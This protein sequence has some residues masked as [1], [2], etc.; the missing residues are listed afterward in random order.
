M[1]YRQTFLRPFMADGIITQGKSDVF[2]EVLNYLSDA[3]QK[4]WRKATMR[5]DYTDEQKTIYKAL[6][7]KFDKEY[8]KVSKE[9][10]QQAQ[11]QQQQGTHGQTQPTNQAPQSSNQIGAYPGGATVANGVNAAAYPQQS[12]LPPATPVAAPP[13][14]AAQPVERPEPSPIS[15]PA[16]QAQS[17]APSV[18]GMKRAAEADGGADA[19][20]KRIKSE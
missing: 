7:E 13:T 18:A 1:E 20:A 15:A 9:K 16:S 4:D 17:P 2:S 12:Q 19:D 11:R 3:H 10:E 8:V 14:Q 5:E 6:Y